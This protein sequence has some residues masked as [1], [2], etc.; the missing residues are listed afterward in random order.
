MGDKKVKHV[1][2]F[3]S[4]A[5][6]KAAQAAKYL[7]SSPNAKEAFLITQKKEDTKQLERKENLKQLEINHTR[8]AA[9]EAR[10][11]KEHELDMAKRRAEYQV[12]LELERDEKKFEKQQMMMEETRKREE[13]SVLRQESM[14][15][16]TIDFEYKKKAELKERMINYQMQK[17]LENQ[18]KAQEF[19]KN[20]IKLQGAERRENIRTTLSTLFQY[21]G[22]GAQSFFS[23][24]KLMTKTATFI[25]GSITAILLARAGINIMSAAMLSRFGK[26]VL[27]KETSKISTDK[28]LKLP[29]LLGQ[30]AYARVKQKSTKDLMK[31]IILKPELEA[32]IRA[33]SYAVLNRKK[34]YAPYRNFLFYGPPGTGK[35]LFAKRLALKSGM[36]YAVMSGADISPLGPAAIHE[37]H[38]L[39]NWANKTGN[40]IILFIDEADAFLRKRRGDQP[41]SE[42]LRNAI[43]A[44]L[45]RTGSQSDKFMLVL[46]TNTPEQ[47]DDAILD[48][49]DELVLFEKPGL[50]ERIDMLY[51]YLLLYCNPPKTT[52]EKLKFLWKHPKSLYTGRK[53]I[54]ME[55]VDDKVIERMAKRA[56]GFSGRELVKM[57]VAWHDA[58]F[59]QESPVLT[60][61]VME[62]ILDRLREMHGVKQTWGEKESELLLK[63]QSPELVA[64]M[65]GNKTSSKAEDADVSKTG[66]NTVAH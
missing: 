7:D 5:L 30:R 17:R 22:S 1:Y 18:A 48:R 13:D 6:E 8:I 46:A 57:V 10:R 62:K 39:F 58:A 16:Q 41:L 45:Y 63:L 32:Q 12:Q 9:E 21:L 55:G 23:S 28:L 11:T 64:A 56:E 51:H 3:D 52:Y 26:P 2:G 20:L 53:L 65:Q 37:L 14:R 49:V 50:Q 54:G 35:T 60:P 19:Q 43:N 33:I 4:S 59:A 31:G 36:D 24:P 27:I 40:G 29:F 66:E 42:N 25:A 44:F 15:R 38:S 34:H 61:E 47:L